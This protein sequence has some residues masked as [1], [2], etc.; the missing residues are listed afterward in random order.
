M[1][2]GGASDVD[3]LIDDR[4]AG[5]GLMLAMVVVLILAWRR[6][7]RRGGLQLMGRVVV[8]AGA[9]ATEVAA[10]RAVA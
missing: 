4:R 2:A 5:A 10:P 7:G 6:V 1:T 9:T 3:R 8:L